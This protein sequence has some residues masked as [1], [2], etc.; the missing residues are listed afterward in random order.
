MQEFVK[1]WEK[2][3]HEIWETNKTKF[4]ERYANSNPP[5]SKFDADIAR[6]AEV[7]NNVQRDESITTVNFV[8]LDCSSLKF[9]IIEH[10]NE[11]QTRFTSL[12]Y[13]ISCKKLL[14]CLFK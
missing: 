3:Y 12:L 5:L 14:V 13:D 10:C 1:S 7:A 4:I 8:V 11:W 2:K 9:S 6:Y